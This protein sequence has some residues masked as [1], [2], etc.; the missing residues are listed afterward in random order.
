MVRLASADAKN[1]RYQTLA[2]QGVMGVC[3]EKFVKA[4]PEYMA[5]FDNKEQYLSRFSKFRGLVITLLSE[6]ARQE[7]CLCISVLGERSA[8]PPTS[9]RAKA[10]DPW[11]V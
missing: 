2:Q 9:F 10:Y 1:H 5:E 6:C 8:P 3:L 7:P 11:S 4:P